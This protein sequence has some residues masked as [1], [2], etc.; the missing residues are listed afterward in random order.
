MV[1]I[2]VN[3]SARYHARR[4]RAP[5]SRPAKCLAVATPLR[6]AARRGATPACSSAWPGDMVHIDVNGSARYHARRHRAPRS[7]PATRSAAATPWR[8]AARRGA[9]PWRAARRG[10]AAS[11]REAARRGGSPWRA[12]GVG[13][14]R[15]VH[16][17]GVGRQRAWGS[18]GRLSARSS[19]SARRPFRG[20]ASSARAARVGTAE[21]TQ[22]D[23]AEGS[24][25]ER[26]EGPK[27]ER[28][29][30]VLLSYRRE[31]F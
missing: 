28:S 27:R 26:D 16:Q 6:E 15:G 14:H 7:R 5:R 13:P 3:G 10:G 18:P 2:D 29:V 17:L 21:S 31:A 1:H 20:D 9:T 24:K 23:R 11:W 4:H 22:V 30:P 25:R 12:L 8:E 19:Q